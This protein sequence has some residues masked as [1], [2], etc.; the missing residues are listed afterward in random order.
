MTLKHVKDIGHKEPPLLPSIHMHPATHLGLGCHCPHHSLL[1][2]VASSLNLDGSRHTTIP[3][4]LYVPDSL[5]AV[6]APV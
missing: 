1:L 5:T 6:A 4:A 2:H 3:E